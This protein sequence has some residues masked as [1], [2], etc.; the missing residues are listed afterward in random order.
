MTDG[1]LL[2][3]EAYNHLG[4]RGT[5]ALRFEAKKAKSELSFIEFD[6]KTSTCTVV[7]NVSTFVCTKRVG[8]AGLGAGPPAKGMK[9]DLVQGWIMKT[10]PASLPSNVLSTYALSVWPHGR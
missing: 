9:Y 5:K 4:V 1:Q 8:G 6:K 10:A 7:A 3:R 2:L